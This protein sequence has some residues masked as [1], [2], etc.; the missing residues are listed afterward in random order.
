[1]K[2]LICQLLLILAASTVHAE[3][4]AETVSDWLCGSIFE[5]GG[6]T[7]ALAQDGFFGLRLDIPNKPPQN[8][9]G[10]WRLSPDGVELILATLQDI[11]LKLT[12]GKDGVHALL[13]PLGNVTLLPSQSEKAVFQATGYLDL[14]PEGA[15]LTDAASGRSFPVIAKPE[16]K[17]GKFAVVEIEIGRGVAQAGNM[18]QHSGAVPRFYEL[19][20]AEQTVEAFIKEACDRFWL[21]PYLSGVEK[22][23]IRFSPPRQKGKNAPFEGSFEVVGEGLRLEG[24]Y[25]LTEDKLTTYAS[26]AS[27]HNLELIGAGAVAAAILGEF[28]WR[29]SSRGLELLGN[30]RP[31][32]LSAI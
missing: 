17:S 5:G 2:K 3:R 29:L 13:G 26:G 19:P 10:L 21:M 30:K 16:A 1:M 32:L 15:I 11:E 12:V 14:Q 25:R 4:N 20:A 24:R 23:G 18:L 7:L 27:V 31:M 8:M 22:A 9:T 6:A 28:G